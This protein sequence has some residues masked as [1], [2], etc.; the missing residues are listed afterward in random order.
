MGESIFQS[1]EKVACVS[2]A[3]KKT[4][5]LNK[6]NYRPISVLNAFSKVLE[7]FFSQPDDSIPQ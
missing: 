3:F 6:E 2:P 4:D 7:R 5:G 1:V